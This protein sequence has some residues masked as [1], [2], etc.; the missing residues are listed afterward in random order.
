VEDKVPSSNDGTRGAQPQR[1]GGMKVRALR[2][3]A[4]PLA[5]IASYFL[6][7][8]LFLEIVLSCLH[9]GPGPKGLCSG[10]WYENHAWIGAVVFGLALFLGPVLLP[11]VLAPRFKGVVGVLAL[12]AVAVHTISEF[13]FWAWSVAM[14]IVVVSAAAFGIAFRNRLFRSRGA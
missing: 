14:P 11:V 12:G 5:L 6:A 8:F 13:D 2:W 10:W 1:L 4:V 3:V 9:F 7:F